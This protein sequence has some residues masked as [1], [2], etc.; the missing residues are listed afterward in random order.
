MFTRCWNWKC[1]LA[2]DLAA[3]ARKEAQLLR[4][5]PEAASDAAWARSQAASPTSSASGG[6]APTIAELQQWADEAIADNLYDK[7][8]DVGHWP[9]GLKRRR[10]PSTSQTAAKPRY[11]LRRA[12]APRSRSQDRRCTSPPYW[13]PPCNGPKSY[14]SLLPVSVATTPPAA[15][16]SRAEEQGLVAALKSYEV[17]EWLIGCYAGCMS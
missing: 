1:G 14:S 11:A 17:Q 9:P 4:S 15:P 6:D 12:L 7:I 3:K 13:K 16:P 2:G 10:R 8:M 5:M